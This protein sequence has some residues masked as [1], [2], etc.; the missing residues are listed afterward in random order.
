MMRAPTAPAYR[1][2]VERLAVW[3]AARTGGR[4]RAVLVVDGVLAA[5]LGGLAGQGSWVTAADR[6]RT[7]GAVGFGPVRPRRTR[8]RR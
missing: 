2:G 6:G 1:R 8:A 5:V 3:W 4:V 7:L